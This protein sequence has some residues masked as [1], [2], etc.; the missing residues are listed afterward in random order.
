[1]AK[2][3]NGGG[4]TSKSKAKGG[5]N[6]SKTKSKQASN[7]KTSNKKGGSSSSSS[8]N[9]KAR[10][11]VSPYTNEKV[12]IAQATVKDLKSPQTY[13]N[14]GKRLYTITSEQIRYD[15]YQQVARIISTF[16][17]NLLP[18]S[19]MRSWSVEVGITE[20]D[21]RVLF[22]PFKG[23]MELA[24]LPHLLERIPDPPVWPGKRLQPPDEYEA[25]EGM[26]ED[27]YEDGLGKRE[28]SAL[29]CLAFDELRKHPYRY[30]IP[31]ITM[32]WKSPDGHK[33]FTSRTAAW[34]HAKTLCQKE[35]MINRHLLGIGPSGKNLQ[36]FVPSLPNAL[37]V[38]QLRFIRDGLWKVGQE[39]EWQDG[40]EEELL[41][42]KAE[43]EANATPKVYTSGLQLYIATNRKAYR[44]DPK[45]QCQ[46]LAQADKKLRLEWRQLK[47]HQQEEWNDKVQAQFSSDED[48]EEE[49]VVE[50]KKSGTDTKDSGSDSSSDDGE[51]Y[52]RPST[53]FLQSRRQDYRYEQ[54]MKLDPTG[55]QHFTLAQ[56]DRDL[57][58]IWNGMTQEEKDDWLSSQT[59]DDEAM[60]NKDTPTSGA[61]DI[62]AE[63]ITSAKDSEV[64]TS[65]KTAIETETSNNAQLV[66]TSSSP[67]S[68]LQVEQPS[69]NAKEAENTDQPAAKTQVDTTNKSSDG[70]QE[71]KKEDD[72]KDKDRSGLSC[73]TQTNSAEAHG[74]SEL[75]PAVNSK[76][77]ADTSA[78]ADQTKTEEMSVISPSM[79]SST[80]S[81]RKKS[82]AKNQKKPHN[83]SRIKLPSDKASRRW[84]LDDEKV[85]LCKDECME[86]YEA[87]MRTVKGRNLLQELED[88]FDVMRERGR[89]RFDMTLP[90]F[91]EPQFDFLTDPKKT[92]W[93]PVVRA[94]L[95]DDAVLVHKGCFLSL[96]GAEKQVYHQDG[97]HLNNQ[98]QRPCHAINVFVPLIDLHARN[99]PTEFVLGSH[100][101]GQEGFDKDFTETPMPKAGT[102]IIF[103]YRLGHRGLGNS[104]DKPRPILYT[105]YSANSAEGKTFV[106]SVNFS[107]NMTTGKK[108]H[109]IGDLSAKPLSREERRNNR[110]RSIESRQLE[111]MKKSAEECNPQQ[112]KA[113]SETANESTI[114]QKAE[115]TVDQK[116]G[117][118]VVQKAGS[119]VEKKDDETNHL[120][121]QEK[122]DQVP[123]RKRSKKPSVVGD[124]NSVP[125]EVAKSQGLIT[126]TSPGY[127]KA[128]SLDDT[129]SSV[130]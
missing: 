64:T 90:V 112:A 85:E 87:V 48:S 102:P 33:P 24:V 108:Y 130:P 67:S 42:E 122:L 119:A 98:T 123:E 20:L 128:G 93:M 53:L 104:S 125:V 50:S 1:M 15:H 36:P 32:K 121:P 110:K 41:E 79:T 26:V 76:P 74:S 28:M 39:L 34:D 129:P 3:K 30:S 51:M 126:S 62:P 60:D 8:S 38:G 80:S 114:D 101:L 77:P 46:N 66:S 49:S 127:A 13:R 63:C 97:V 82:P 103:D 47:P 100:V 23:K 120:P 107:K 4:A 91:D 89:G 92:P 73:Q 10:F 6:K 94:I 5:S 95:G 113:E 25:M 115:S 71:E 29:S 56:A 111:E 18:P 72:Q 35:V 31:Q 116:T 7:G 81:K 109:K 11:V 21:G 69:I 9:S 40:R 55:R 105:T 99:G 59:D 52:V 61:Q 86:H 22:R 65:E 14:D 16:E 117:S 57:M 12:F 75:V 124:V 2:S 54:Q 70:V 106:D 27:S 19:G 118:P 43:A 17:Q 58:A 68:D 88:G 44:E 84:C 78:A 96:P 45:N 83:S 37:K